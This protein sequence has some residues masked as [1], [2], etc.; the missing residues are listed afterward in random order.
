MQR[1]AV[2]ALAVKIG[3]QLDKAT[4]TEKAE[5]RE[6]YPIRWAVR[7]P[8]HQTAGFFCTLEDAYDDLSN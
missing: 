4:D 1:S 8:G 7:E 6:F 2:E 3:L 5:N